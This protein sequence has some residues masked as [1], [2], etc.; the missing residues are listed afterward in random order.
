MIMGD[1][2][3][4]VDRPDLPVVAKFLSTLVSFG[5]TQHIVAAT[6]IDGHTLDLVITRSS[7]DFIYDSFVSDL[8]SDHFAVISVVRAHKPLL[9]KKK[10]SY[11]CF[12]AIDA[13]ELASDISQ[14]SLV[15]I[16]ASSMDGLL[17]QYEAA[18]TV[19]LDRLAPMKT[20]MSIGRPSSP[21]FSGD[22]VA[23]RCRCRKLE[24]VWRRRRLTIEKDILLY[25]F[26][27]LRILMNGTKALYFKSKIAEMGNDRLG[28]FQQLDRC[29][30]RNRVSKLPVQAD[31]ATLADRFGRYFDEKIVN[32]RVNLDAMYASSVNLSSSVPNSLLS[33]FEP[34]SPAE[35]CEMVDKCPAKSSFADPIPTNILKKI[36]HVLAK[37]FASL[38]NLSV[39]SGV[40]PD[41]M[42]LAS[43]TPLLKKASLNPKELSNFR[44]V[45]GLSFLSKLLERV[46]LRRLTS[47]MLS[48]D[49]MVPVQ[50]AYRAN[51][52]T[53]TALLRVMNDLL[54]A[55]DNGDGAALVLFDLSAAFDTIDHTVH[56]EAAG[57]YSYY[58][59]V[60]IRH[61]NLIISCKNIYRK[62]VARE[63][64]RR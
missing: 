14:S 40:F 42:K 27:Q 9:L 2:N 61:V 23:A 13:D 34:V 38:I 62:K 59:L 6:H 21:W 26:R 60:L 43:I 50:S 58:K 37:P 32:I 54:L 48:L 24:R 56:C 30:S 29:L 63:K 46:V 18:V 64:K 35:I 41:S 12:S 15:C 39:S 44:P 28:L 51:H 19:A 8:I 1:F 5:L 16:P 55:V 49:L 3:I 45:S 10:I 7:D 53:E 36:I 17:L 57:V 22:I 47:H 11:R 4:H 31:P 20:K 33:V 25:H 52:S